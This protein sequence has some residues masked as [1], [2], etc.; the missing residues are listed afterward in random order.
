MA[1]LTLYLLR[2]YKIK[3]T[4]MRMNE[5]F[6]AEIDELDRAYRTSFEITKTSLTRI[7]QEVMRFHG[8]HFEI[9]IETHCAMCLCIF[10][11][12][13]KCDEFTFFSNCSLCIYSH[14]SDTRDLL[15]LILYLTVCARKFQKN[16]QTIE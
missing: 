7:I 10:A 4:Y 1:P 2:I 16:H 12:S 13:A 8:Q 5:I 11:C 15:Q 6:A 9:D 14:V 3:E